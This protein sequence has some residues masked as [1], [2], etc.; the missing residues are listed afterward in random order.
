MN[1][2]Y[3]YE[4]YNNCQLGKGFWEDQNINQIFSGIKNQ[5]DIWK[6]VLERKFRLDKIENT[7]LLEFSKFGLTYMHLDSY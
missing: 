6:P 7:V 3:G 5:F 2:W 1:A 4:E